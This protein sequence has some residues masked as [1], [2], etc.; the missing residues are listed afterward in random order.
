[1]EKDKLKTIWHCPHT[2]GGARKF[3]KHS[4][5]KYADQV[6]IG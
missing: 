5:S 2:G 6:L 1:M 3:E 4:L